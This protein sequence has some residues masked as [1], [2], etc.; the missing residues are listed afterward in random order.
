M[1]LQFDWDESKNMNNRSKHGVWFEEAKTVFKDHRGILSVDPV[2]S[3][4]EDR[5]A[6]LGFSTSG[7]VLVVIHCYRESDSVIRIISA[8]KATKSEEKFYEKGI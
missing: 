4:D 6:M 8:R 1:E 2:H 7:R 3:H 5:F